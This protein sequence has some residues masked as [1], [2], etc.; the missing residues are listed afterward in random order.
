MSDIPKGYVLRNGGAQLVE[1]GVNLLVLGDVLGLVSPLVFYRG[2]LGSDETVDALVPDAP[3]ASGL[4]R[5]GAL[6]NSL[7]TLQSA[8]NAVYYQLPGTE[9]EDDD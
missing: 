8:A 6:Q 1:R 7:R 5:G 3:R 9:G 4:R 2:D